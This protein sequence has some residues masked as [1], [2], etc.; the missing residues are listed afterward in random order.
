ME[1][2]MPVSIRYFTVLISDLKLVNETTVSSKYAAKIA[3]A[4]E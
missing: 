1:R 4:A 3:Q 2:T